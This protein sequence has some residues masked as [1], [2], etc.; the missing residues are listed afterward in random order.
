[1]GFITRGFGVSVHRQDCPNAHPDKRKPEEAGRWVKVSWGESEQT[2][3]QTSLEISAKDRDALALD[4]TMA[5]TAAKV[6]VSSFSARSLPDGYA[7]VSVV[8]E[9]KDRNELTSL[10][11]KLGQISGVYQVKRASG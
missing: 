1:M 7:L 4:V 5:L 8:L 11:N 2:T 9:V 6:R 3:Y 10:I